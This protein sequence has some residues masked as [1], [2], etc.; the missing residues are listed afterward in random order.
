MAKTVKQDPVAELTL[1]IEYD[2]LPDRSELNELIEKARE[3][4]GVIKAE[5][6]IK[7]LTVVDL[8]K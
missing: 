6:E 1:I 4:G 8:L 7:R 5:L 2:E 3:V